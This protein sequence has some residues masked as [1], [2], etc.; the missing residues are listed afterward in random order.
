MHVGHVPI[1]ALIMWL[2]IIWILSSE[3]LGL[4]AALWTPHPCW[5]TR[6]KPGAGREVTAQWRTRRRRRR[7]HGRHGAKSHLVSSNGLSQSPCSL[8]HTHVGW[9][10]LYWPQSSDCVTLSLSHT[11]PESVT[12]SRFRV[13]VRW[14]TNLKL[15]P[16]SQNGKI[17]PSAYFLVAS[18]QFPIA[19]D[20]LNGVSLTMTQR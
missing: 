6:T 17:C 18:R 16:W 10:A 20:V 4:S 14:R 3:R 13:F 2:Y 19:S 8:R 1:S 12:L 7:E 5:V 11:S 15:P 9:V